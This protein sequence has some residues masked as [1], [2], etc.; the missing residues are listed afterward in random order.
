MTFIWRQKKAA[1]YTLLIVAAIILLSQAKITFREDYATVKTI[2]G[3]KANNQKISMELPNENSFSVI[4]ENEILRLKFDQTTGHFIVED[5]R[6]GNLYRSYPDPEQWDNPGIAGNW[7]GH[8]QSPIMIQYIDFTNSNARPIDTNFV[9]Q[10]GR[11][12]DVKSIPGGVEFVLELSSIGF[13]FP[14]RL[15]IKDDYV[16]TTLINEG[17]KEN[18]KESL[19]WLRLYPFFSAVQSEKQDGY[20]FIPD[21]S[22][23]LIPFNGKNSSVKQ[24]YQERIYGSDGSFINNPSSRNNILMPVFGMKSGDKAY[25]A[26]VQDGA[27]FTDIIASPSGVNSNYNWIG[28]QQY[29]RMKYMQITSRAKSTGFE[30]YTK[31]DR[32]DEDRVTRYYFL[33]KG[34]T[35]Y[36][37]MASRYRQYLMEDLG[38]KRIT[39]KSKDIPLF[40]SI[41]GAD[42]EKGL[43]MD[44]Y[45]KATSFSEAMQM[46]QEL[47]G[48]GVYN[49]NVTYLGWQKGGYSSLGG[50]LPVDD[51]IGGKAGLKN[52]IDY[53]HELDIPVSL[54]V[55]Y[56]VN[57]SNVNGFMPRYGGARNLAGTIMDITANNGDTIN[58]VSRKFIEK[59]V[60]HDINDFKS[61]GVDGLLMSDLGRFVSTDYNTEYGGSRSEV[62][63]SDQ[64]IIQTVKESLGSV[65]AS[66][67][68]FYLLNKV[69]HIDQLSD[70]YSYDLF[71]TGPIPFAQIALHGLMTYTSTSENSRSQY[72]IDFL[73]DIE[74]GAYPSFDFTMADSTD[75]AGAYWY[76]PKSSSFK[77][78]KTEAVKQY[79]QYNNTFAELQDQ[80]IVEHKQIA[81]GVSEVVYE[82]GTQIYVNYNRTDFRINGVEVPAMNYT[83]VKRGR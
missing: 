47:N 77:D 66:Q 40:L 67:A 39:P 32:F 52:F 28:T 82:N 80:F 69:N 63:R 31:K 15:R 24:I 36:V 74:N 42:R 13:E 45:V 79:Q 51:R 78:W 56:E 27:V 38:L 22:G 60:K 49:M 34:H 46:V 55:N 12:K 23:A 59:A 83:V 25:L 3:S 72:E 81:E 33:D 68:G 53:A 65:Q 7:I 73:R 64:E 6:N 5:K 44:R 29:Y 57:N 2:V 41:L 16:E 71:S 18:G 48:L 21:G 76:F 10:Q 11:L 20:L 35:D 62:I 4:A 61:L 17:I 50:Y 43:L 26:V 70:D 30:T 1:F 14:V 75:L 54:E 37:G 58:L 19:L 8:L 9:K